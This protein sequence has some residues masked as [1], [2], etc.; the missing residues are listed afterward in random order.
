MVQGRCQRFI[1]NGAEPYYNMVS[2]M[3]SSMHSS[4]TRNLVF[5]LRPGDGGVLVLVRVL[6]RVTGG[7]ESWFTYR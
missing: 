1:C 2:D 5:P 7:S 3:T 4:N 6:S